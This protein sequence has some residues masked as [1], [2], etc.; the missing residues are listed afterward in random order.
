VGMWAKTW[1]GIS[2]SVLL[3]RLFNEETRDIER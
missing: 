1:A 3:A 2:V